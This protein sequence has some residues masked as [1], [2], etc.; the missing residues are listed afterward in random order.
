[1]RAV[2]PPLVF[3]ILCA[4]APSFHLQD[5]EVIGALALRQAYLRAIGRLAVR[6]TA[7]ERDGRDKHVRF[8]IEVCVCV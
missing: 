8:L 4:R 1:M 6:I 3:F 7:W 5:A 2:G